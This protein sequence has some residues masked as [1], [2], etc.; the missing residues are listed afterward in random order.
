MKA[1]TSSAIYVWT[2]IAALIVLAIINNVSALEPLKDQI[3]GKS[4]WF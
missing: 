4:G 3:S 2:V 1:N